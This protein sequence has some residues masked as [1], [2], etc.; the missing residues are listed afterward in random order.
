[1]STKVARPAS[2]LPRADS[3]RPPR[4]Q[5]GSHGA[6]ASNEFGYELWTADLVPADKQY[7]Q[8]DVPESRRVQMVSLHHPNMRL[9]EIELVHNSFAHLHL[10]NRAFACL[11][12]LKYFSQSLQCKVATR[13]DSPSPQIHGL[14]KL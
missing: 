9:I 3:T 2:V 8:R 4:G 7:N 12:F 5:P 6:A 14:C 10:R 13:C 11:S 1:M